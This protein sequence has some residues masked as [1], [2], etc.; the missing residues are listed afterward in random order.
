M[1]KLKIKV[2]RLDVKIAI[3]VGI[4]LLTAK[5]VPTIQYMAAA[6]AAILCMQDEVK[7]SWKT[8]VNRMILTA[9]G[10]VTGVIII[11]LDQVIQ[12]EWIFLIMVML[13]II[14]TL[15]GCK[16]AKVPYINARIGAVTFVLIVMV[17]SGT[18]RINYAGMRL[19]GTFY[20]ILVSLAITWLFGLFVSKKQSKEIIKENTN[21][22]SLTEV[23]K[24]GW[25]PYLPLNEYIP[26]GEP[27]VFNGR[28]YIFGSHDEE[29]GDKFCPLDYVAWS[30][31][32]GDLSD[33]TCHGVIYKKEQDPANMDGSHRLYAPDVVQGNDGRYYLFYGLDLIPQI[34]VAVCDT[35]A[36]KYDYLGKVQYADGTVLQDNMPFDPAVINDDGHIYLYYGFAPPFPIHGKTQSDC[37]GCSFVELQEDMLTVKEPPVVVLPAKQYAA[38]TG[39]EG[40]EFFEAASIR[41]IKDTYYLIYSSSEIHELCYAIS[42][43]SD[44][45]FTYGGVIVSNGDIGLNGRTLEDS[46]WSTSNNHGSLVEAGHKW[47][48]FYHRHTHG[49]MYCRQGCAEHVE[50]GENGRIA[51]V[52]ITSSGLAHTPLEATGE[53]PAAIACNLWG[54]NGAKSPIYGKIIE[55]APIVSSEDGKQFIS[56][57]EDGTVIG[58][59]YF[60]FCGEMM[61]KLKYRGNAKGIFK[62]SATAD[63][64]CLGVVS[65]IPTDD[66]ST[67]CTDIERKGTSGLFFRYIG[68]GSVQLIS[69]EFEK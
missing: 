34:A 20:G 50:I 7:V 8:G 9:V 15:L 4:C 57:I 60:N 44:K 28:L 66:W 43:S 41:K 10:G 40:H 35:P 30:T 53:Y 48:I 49:T 39:F 22:K 12:N 59:K 52:E 62:I 56:Q 26:D 21:G 38:G 14:L 65:I 46:V 36:G 1:D 19:I 61:L 18:A 11:L 25:N 69:F 31:P 29:A 33:W 42:S 13:G 47:Y 54:K 17:A 58:Y 2:S 3:A 68:M 16:V 67:V 45:G 27:H 24:R 63:G 23:K 32:E 6:F 5:F 37:P 51:Q 55:D 64:K